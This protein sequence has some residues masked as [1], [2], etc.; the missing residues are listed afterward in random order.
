VITVQ[1]VDSSL[2]QQQKALASL[3]GTIQPAPLTI[4]STSLPAPVVGQAYSAQL[5]ASGGTS[6]YTWSI[7][8]GSLPPGLELNASTGEITGTP[9][10][11]GSFTLTVQVTDS[12]VAA[13]SSALMIRRP[14]TRAQGITESAAARHDGLFLPV[15]RA[16][17]GYKRS[18]A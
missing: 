2:L 7:V 10:E 14:C 5:R 8:E 15:A 4:T 1:V 18:T 11:A 12:S 17:I 13:N 16:E 9:T 6:P 3:T